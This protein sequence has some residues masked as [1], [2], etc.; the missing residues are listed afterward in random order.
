MAR[1]KALAPVAD[2]TRTIL[3]LRRQRVILDADLAKLYGVPTKALN[4]AV[5]R[6]AERFPLDFMFGLTRDE[7]QNIQDSRSQNVT[8][9]RG[10]NIKYLPYA[11]TEHGALMA[12]NLLKSPRAVAMSVYV[13]RAFVK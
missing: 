4:Q 13:I 1:S 6:N 12:A 7:A 2:I 5:K 10:Q 11:F 3:V 8:L 9:N